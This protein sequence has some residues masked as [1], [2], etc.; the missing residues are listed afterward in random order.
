MSKC[1]FCRRCLV[2]L[3]NR[4]NKLLSSAK[5]AIRRTP[6]RKLCRKVSFFF[7]LFFFVGS[8]RHS[9]T[10][11]EWFL[12]N[13]SNILWKLPFLLFVRVSV[14][15]TTHWKSVEFLRSLCSSRI[16]L[17]LL[18]LQTII[19]PAKKRNFSAFSLLVENRNFSMRNSLKKCD[20]FKLKKLY[21]WATKTNKVPK[22][23]SEFDAIKTTTCNAQMY[24]VNEV[25]WLTHNSVVLCEC[26]RCI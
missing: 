17:G 24:K 20:N 25:Q 16:I 3:D 12:K 9:F 7:F 5:D 6:I 10:I 11:N 19:E 2:A 4:K 23:R 22:N 1:T 21:E 14:T 13:F 8:A 26:V 15:M 18:R